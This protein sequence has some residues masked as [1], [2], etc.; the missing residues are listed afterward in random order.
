MSHEGNIYYVGFAESPKVIRLVPRNS[1]S[2][3]RKFPLYEL[4]SG[5]FNGDF[6]GDFNG[7]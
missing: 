5:N 2:F 3:I 7:I 6:N 1:M 4:A